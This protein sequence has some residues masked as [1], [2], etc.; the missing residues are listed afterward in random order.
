MAR[1]KNRK[2]VPLHGTGIPSDLQ[3]GELAVNTTAGQESL[4][5]K[6]SNG[7]IAE[8]DLSHYSILTQAQYDA[9]VTKDPN[10]IYYIK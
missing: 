7:A 9:L 6:N 3:V 5:T 1:N 2:V 10:H 4:F 8:I